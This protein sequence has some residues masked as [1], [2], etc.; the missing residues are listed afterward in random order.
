MQLQRPWKD[1]TRHTHLPG[2]GVIMPKICQQ[3]TQ[4]GSRLAEHTAMQPLGM[5][6]C[7]HQPVWN[8]NVHS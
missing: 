6:P 8:N 4:D 5:R 7:S 2:C 3:A 1:K